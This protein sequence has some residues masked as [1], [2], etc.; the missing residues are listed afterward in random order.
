[1]NL[2]IWKN[3]SF[4]SQNYTIYNY[5]NLLKRAKL[6]GQPC[7][8]GYKQCGILDSFNQTLCLLENETCPLN[9]IE[10]SNSS[11]PSDIFT[12]KNAVNTTLLNDNKTYLH[13]SNA[14]INSTVITEIVF[15]P[16][17]FCFDSEE[18]KL[19]PPEYWCEI[20]STNGTC[21]EYVGYETY[22]RYIS[23]DKYTKFNVYNENL[24][25]IQN[26]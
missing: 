3:T 15:G 1:M 21:T 25:H 5:F 16:E 11:T 12:N 8:E 2:A 7:D 19:G 14:E 22:F 17:S 18:R 24:F 13:T 4:I 23:L 10:L 20:S 9:Q 6:P 26:D